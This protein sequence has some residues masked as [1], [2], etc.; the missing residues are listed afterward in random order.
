M[1]Y[2]III[3]FLLACCFAKNSLAAISSKEKKLDI[4]E[5]RC[6]SLELRID[7]LILINDSLRKSNDTIQK[8]LDSSIVSQSVFRKEIETK[9]SELEKELED[10][11]IE[12]NNKVLRSAQMEVLAH[13]EWLA[14]IIM[15]S[16][17]RIG[18]DSLYNNQIIHAIERLGYKNI[19]PEDYSVFYP[20]LLKYK[21]YNKEIYILLNTIYSTLKNRPKANI[22]VLENDFESGFAKSRYYKEIVSDTNR[23]EEQKINYLDRVIDET[24]AL[25][26]KP[27]DCTAENFKKLLNKVK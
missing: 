4:L 15:Q 2:K 11:K 26:S 3:I 21:D 7:S 14:I 22:K 8:S 10:Q 23:S 18:Y 20:L 19:F 5:Q 17:L 6:L 1:K 27:T 25:F 12:C 9:V 13:D 16:P 24:R